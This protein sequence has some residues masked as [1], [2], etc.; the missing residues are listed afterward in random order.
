MAQS[1]AFYTFGRAVCAP[2]MK[3]F[4][5][6]KVINK[7]N[8]PN[9]GKGYI[10]ASNHLSFSDPVLL[11]LGQKRRL[12]FMA[13]DELFKNKFFAF[14]IRHLGAFPVKRGAGDG[15]AIKN[16]ED[17]LNEGNIMT[18][19]I[20]GGRSK[21]GELMRARSGFAV[22]AQQTGAPVVPTCITNVGKGLFG[23]RIIHF[24]DPITVEE[25]GLDSIDRRALKNAGKIVM[26]KIKEMREQDL[27]DYK[28]S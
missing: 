4:Y 6:Y 11:G 10:I 8:I 21:T 22:I 27:N 7:A 2:I 17:I 20:E 26:G 13:K 19:F 24:S 12:N 14:I 9:D 25:L 16:G 15:K 18:I 3:I 5:R 1:K 28:R 23:K